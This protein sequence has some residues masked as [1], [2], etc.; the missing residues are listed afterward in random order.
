MKQAPKISTTEVVSGQNRNV[1]IPWSSQINNIRFSNIE[2]M[3]GGQIP[4]P[5]MTYLF[6][7]NS[8]NP[9]VSRFARMQTSR[10]R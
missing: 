8:T 4:R 9:F 1:G 10:E 7:P 3:V 2:E 6:H 5:S